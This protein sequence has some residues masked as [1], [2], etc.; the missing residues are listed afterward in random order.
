[1]ATKSFTTDMK[2]SRK[3]V[4]DLLRVLENDRKPNLNKALKANR[5]SDLSEIKNL[6]SRKDDK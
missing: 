4:T 6:F 5:I 1:M 3:S 2:F